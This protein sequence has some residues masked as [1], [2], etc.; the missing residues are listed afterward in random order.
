[1]AGRRQYTAFAP[2]D[3]VK[4]PPTIHPKAGQHNGT[5]CT[6]GSRKCFARKLVLASSISFAFLFQSKAH[7]L[8]CSSSP[9][10][11]IWF[12][13][14]PVNSIVK[15]KAVP[16]LIV[17]ALMDQLSS[18]AVL[19]VGHHGDFLFDF[20]HLLLDGQ[21]TPFYLSVHFDSK[22]TPPLKINLR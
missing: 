15:G 10:K 16:A 12:C 11:V 19:G 8:R 13:G 7:S 3:E 17:A 6:A 21:N 1:M 9:H 20:Y 4:Q 5:T 14:D 2:F 22:M 18:S